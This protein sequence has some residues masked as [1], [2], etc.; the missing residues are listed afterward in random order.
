MARKGKILGF[1]LPRCHEHWQFAASFSVSGFRYSVCFFV[2][3]THAFYLP[4]VFR[5]D[6]TIH[7]IFCISSSVTRWHLF[8]LIL[9]CLW[10]YI[11]TWVHHGSRKRNLRYIYDISHQLPANYVALLSETSEKRNEGELLVWQLAE[12]LNTCKS[13]CA[14]LFLRDCTRTHFSTPR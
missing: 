3:A 7:M 6:W 14:R 12:P 4:D 8:L 11:H 2:D 10:L 9:K 5:R 13:W 1:L